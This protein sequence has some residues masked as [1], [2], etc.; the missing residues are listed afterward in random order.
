MAIQPLGN[1]QEFYDNFIDSCVKYNGGLQCK[2]TER[3]RIDNLLDQPKGMENYTKVGFKKIKAPPA[4]YKVVKQFW[5]DNKNKQTEEQ[6]GK[7]NTYTN[8]WEAKSFM[9]SVEDT[10]LRG[11]GAGIKEQIW[12]AARD[13]ISEWTGQELTQCSL[14]GIRVYTEGAILAPHVDRLPLVSS[15]IL[16]VDSDV[17]EPWPLEVYSHDGR[18]YNVTSEPG[19]MILYESHSII[20]GRPFKLKG[21][22]VANIFIHFEPTG[23]TARHNSIY[24]SMD[25]DQDVNAQY[26]QAV[27]KGHGGHENELPPYIVEGSEQGRRWKQIHPGGYK[28]PEREQFTTGSTVAHKLAR[29]GTIDGLRDQIVAKRDLV[30]TKDENGWT[31]LHEGIAGG[32]YDVVKLLVDHGADYNSHTHNENGGTALWW[33]RQELDEDHPIIEFLESLGAIEAGPE[34]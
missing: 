13:L 8:N 25:L 9:V 34:L 24:T 1:R 17:D 14:Y 3:D 16:H 23:H 18:A 26:R 7:G 29:E 6:W 19:D 28:Q 5:D 30:N 10:N 27:Q 15:A 22:Y 11:A 32:H 4:L 21:R 33:A 2:D 12:N 20:H 31:P